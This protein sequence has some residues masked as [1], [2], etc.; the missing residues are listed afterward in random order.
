[1]RFACWLASKPGINREALIAELPRFHPDWR[2]FIPGH[3]FEQA[4]LNENFRRLIKLFQNALR[5]LNAPQRRT[6][7]N[8]RQVD[9]LQMESAADHLRG[10]EARLCDR[11][12]I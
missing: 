8:V 10:Y 6:S 5:G 4:R 2:R 9:F 11:T 7:E 12:V 3:P 1:M